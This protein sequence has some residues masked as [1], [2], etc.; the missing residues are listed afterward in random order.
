MASKVNVYELHKDGERYWQ[1]PVKTEEMTARQAV[2][3]NK[4]FS[5][6]CGLEWVLQPAMTDEELQWLGDL[7]SERQAHMEG[8]L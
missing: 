4:K 6:T 5:V 1:L 3:A 2:A 7:A 8:W